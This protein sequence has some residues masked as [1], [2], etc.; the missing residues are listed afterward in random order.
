M[1]TW[2]GSCVAVAVAMAG[3]CSSDWTPSLG[4]STCHGCSPKKTKKDKQTP[5]ISK[6]G[7][8]IVA[9]QVKNPTRIHENAGSIPGLAQ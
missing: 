1:E 2:L 5:K 3:S 8:P 4:I 6:L 9:E 7:V